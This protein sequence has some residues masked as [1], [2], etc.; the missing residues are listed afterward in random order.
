MQINNLYLKN[1]KQYKG[2]HLTFTEGLTGF[3]GKNGS[4]KSTIFEAISMAFY[5]K[6]D[7]IKE[8]LRND[9]ALEKEPVVIKLEFN[10]KGI[11]YKITREY[12]GKSLTPKAVL[13][14]AGKEIC[15]SSGEVNKELRKILKIDYANFRNSF[16]AHQKDLASI[17]N[18]NI[19]E[20]KPSGKCLDLK[21]LMQ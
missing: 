13:I 20:R 21:C 16:F 2:A 6:S 19:S 10:D 4:G 18:M 7:G 17:L 11:D 9:K 5:G 1:F 3:V 12:R 8:S 15:N 14:S